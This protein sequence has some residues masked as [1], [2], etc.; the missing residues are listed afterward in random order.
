MRRGKGPIATPCVREERCTSRPS[1]SPPSPAAENP[2]RHDAANACRRARA[3]TR[4][5]CR[6][7]AASA[8]LGATSLNA[9]MVPPAAA[10][11]PAPSSRCRWCC[12]LSA[13]RA[14]LSDRATILLVDLG[15]S[16]P[17]RW[18]A[19]KRGFDSTRHT[20]N[21]RPDRTQEPQLPGSLWCFPALLGSP[22]I[23]GNL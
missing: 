6:R 19:S 22:D 17:R 18:I 2:N 11:L 16:A 20:E 4:S 7:N 8:T 23:F 9:S 3:R 10:T 21:Y 13:C 1:W 15:A 5:I 12:L 14:C